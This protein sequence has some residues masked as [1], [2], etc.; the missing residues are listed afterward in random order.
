MRLLKEFVKRLLR[1]VGYDLVSYSKGSDPNLAFCKA[2]ESHNVQLIVDIGA[3]TGQYGL[4][5]RRAGYNGPILSFE[6]MKTEPELL[7]RQSKSDSNWMIASPMAIGDHDGLIE[8]NIASNSGSSSLLP[9][10]ELHKEAAPGSAYIGTE[11][12]QIFRLDTIVKKLV[13]DT[14]QNLFLKI[15]V[16]GS[17][18]SVLDGAKETLS[19]VAGILCECSFTPLYSGEAQWLSLVQRI[20][21]MGFE[22]WGVSPGFSDERTG[23]LLQADFLFF[24]RP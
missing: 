14:C 6:P 21:G 9:M 18:W 4:F 15:D 10:L 7:L 11:S 17:E 12:V 1:N 24:R 13:D 22:I 19:R 23:R 5:V 2:L 8:I 16:Q 3:N 20:E